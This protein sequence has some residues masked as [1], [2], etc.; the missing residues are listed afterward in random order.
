M[1]VVYMAEHMVIKR[2]AA[3]K[4]LLPELSKNREQVERFF[5]EARATSLI[6]HPGLVDV[7][8]FGHANECAFIVLELLEGKTLAAR[9]REAGTLPLSEIVAIGRQAA[10]AL[11]AAHSKGIIHRD[12][13]PDNIFLVPDPDVAGGVRVKILDFGIAKL[14]GDDDPSTLK[15]RTGAVMGTPAYMSPEQC[16]STAKVDLRADIYSL[17]CVLFELAVGRRVFPRGGF[18]EV[19]AAHI[20]EPAPTLRSIMPSVSPALEAVVMRAL[21][22][23]ADERQQTMTELRADLDTLVTRRLSEEMAELSP[24]QP[25][26]PGPA[27]EGAPSTTLGHSAAEV[28]ARPQPAS[29]ARLQII[30]GVS[31]G[32]VGLAALGGAAWWGLA[33]RSDGAPPVAKIA[34]PE[35]RATVAPPTASGASAVVK[36]RVT[37]RVESSPG[38]AEVFRSVDGVLVGVTPFVAEVERSAGRALYVLK[39]AGYQPAQAELPASGDGSVL[40]VLARAAGHARREAAPPTTAP[41]EKKKKELVRDGAY[42]PYG[43]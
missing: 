28:I 41:P 25:R 11:A 19:L 33:Q 6:R 1:G 7:L 14:A 24:S 9:L 15:T 38:G 34:A 43:P 8:D 26:L 10:A 23:N 13:K 32:I 40:V 12:L 22:K 39:L 30:G 37:L 16:K 42:D 4:V 17:G 36:P 18:G 27:S 5:N 29:R 3:I 35:V 20:Y 21:A 2:R 31:A